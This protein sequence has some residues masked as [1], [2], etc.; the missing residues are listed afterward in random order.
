MR[1]ISTVR[2][3]RHFFSV[4]ERVELFGEK[5]P[6]NRVHAKRRPGACSRSGV[7]SRTDEFSVPVPTLTLR[8]IRPRA[9][10]ESVIE[11][12]AG[13]IID[14]NKRENENRRPGICLIARRN[15]SRAVFV[16]Q[17]E[18]RLYSR[19]RN[20]MSV[21]L[22]TLSDAELRLKLLEYGYDVPVTHTTRS[23]YVKKLKNLIENRSGNSGGG[24]GGRGSRHTLAAR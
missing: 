23:T 8:D 10:A 16:L 22:D 12:Q 4:T 7:T 15:H 24:G 9:R 14:R 11:E 17:Q 2:K 5:Q 20:K 13:L 19:A 3:L 6:R 1:A 18:S 21:N